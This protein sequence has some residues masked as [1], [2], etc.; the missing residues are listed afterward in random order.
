MLRSKDKR[1]LIVCA[2][3]MFL[4]YVLFYFSWKWFYE[5]GKF[6]SINDVNSNNFLIKLASDG[7]DLIIPLTTVFLMW[8][9]RTEYN[10]QTGN[11]KIFYLCMTCYVL[12]FVLLRDEYYCTSVTLLLF[13]VGTLSLQLIS[14]YMK[15][16]L[17]YFVYYYPWRWMFVLIFRM[18]MTG[19]IIAVF[20]SNRK[21][22]KQ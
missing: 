7:L 4:Y 16:K 19:L 1:A 2:V 9:Q 20:L 14:I 11:K 15:E 17:S 6:I 22:I 12:N 5:H 10:L 8:K 3:I 21:T 18:W 13:T